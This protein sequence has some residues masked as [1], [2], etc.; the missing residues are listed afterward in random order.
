MRKSFQVLQQN[1][2]LM[3]T[4]KLNSVISKHHYIK[5]LKVKVL[6]ILYSYHQNHYGH[7]NAKD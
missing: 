6:K 3:Q 2:L 4:K 5:Y 7:K 1:S